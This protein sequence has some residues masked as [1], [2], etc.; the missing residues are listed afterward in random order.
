MTVIQ[1]GTKFV[2]TSPP[3]TPDASQLGDTIGSPKSPISGTKKSPLKKMSLAEYQQN[4]AQR[5]GPQG[6]VSHGANMDNSEL[7]VSPILTRKTSPNLEGEFHKT[8]TSMGQTPKSRG[9]SPG[10]MSFEKG[11]QGIEGCNTPDGMDMMKT[12]TPKSSK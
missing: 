7:D 9:K 10:V 8:M 11:L 6:P 2:G 3:E 12:M 5:R 1:N 4:A